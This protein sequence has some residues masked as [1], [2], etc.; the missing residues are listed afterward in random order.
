MCLFC[1]PLG[2]F[3]SDWVAIYSYDT[4]VCAQPYCIL[5]GDVRWISLGVLLFFFFLMGNR[6]GVDRGKRNG[7]GL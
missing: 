7:T 5:S 2:Y 6:G 3:S 1:L 4:T